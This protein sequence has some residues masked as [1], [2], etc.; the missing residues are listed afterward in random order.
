MQDGKYRAS[1]NPAFEQCD[2]LRVQKDFVVA[3]DGQHSIHK[4]REI[5]MHAV[6]ETA[7]PVVLDVRMTPPDGIPCPLNSV[8]I[9]GD[10]LNKSRG[11]R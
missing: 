1:L 11:H 2:S 6:F 9:H 3:K 10:L 4:S 7:Y 8:E 5:N